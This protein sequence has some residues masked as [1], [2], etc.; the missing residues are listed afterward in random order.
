MTNEQSFFHF[1][2]ILKHIHFGK[3]EKTPRELQDAIKTDNSQQGTRVF[4]YHLALR[5]EHN[6][7]V[8]GSVAEWLGRQTWN[9]EAPGLGLALAAIESFT[10][11]PG[12]TPRSHL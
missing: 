6:H 3:G 9:V 7:Q 12:S 4:C 2:L 1:H 5:E 8:V 11:N 10:A